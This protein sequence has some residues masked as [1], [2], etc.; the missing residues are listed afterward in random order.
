M[1]DVD[2]YSTELKG[3]Y[4]TLGTVRIVLYLGSWS[5][6]DETLSAQGLERIA[7]VTLTS[8]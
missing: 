6:C 7:N 8:G 1:G 4:H 2:N 3:R 5:G